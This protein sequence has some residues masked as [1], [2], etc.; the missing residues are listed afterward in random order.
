MNRNIILRS[1]LKEEFSKVRELAQIIWPICYKNI[2]SIEQISY[3]MDMMY[4]TSVIEKEVEEGIHYYFIELDS[5]IA[6]YVAW[7]PWEN[8]PSTAKLHKLYLLPQMQGQKIGN[9]VINLVKQQVKASGCCRIRLNVNRENNNAIKC[10][11]NN[12]FTMVQIENN[13]IGNGFYMMDY[14]MEAKV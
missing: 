13:D 2:L 10:Y 5:Q 11:S 7:G 3:M 12:N 4:S 9:I 6:G 14:V 1:V 8:V